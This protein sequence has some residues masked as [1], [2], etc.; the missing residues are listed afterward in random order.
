MHVIGHHDRAVEFDSLSVIV[1]AVLQ[2]DVA[3]ICRKRVSSQPAE[4]HKDSP[5]RLLVMRQATAVVVVVGQRRGLAHRLFKPRPLV[6][7]CDGWTIDLVAVR[8][9]N[10]SRVERTL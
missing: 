4:S 10:C 3:G 8:V 9:W 7:V 1:Y 5:V 2:N 6:A